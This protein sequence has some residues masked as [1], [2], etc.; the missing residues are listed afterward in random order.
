MLTFHGLGLDGIGT[1][2]TA[3]PA[4]PG[5]DR[6]TPTDRDVPD[7]EVG[8]IV[9]RGPHVF[10]GYFNRPELTA[11]HA[12]RRLAPHR[13]TSAGARTD[14][15][16][17][18]VGPK[19]RMI[20]S[21]GEN[22][23][24]AEVERALT[25]H[26]HVDAAAVIGLPDATWG[27]NVAAVVVRSEGATVTEQELIEHVRAADR[28]LQEAQVGD[29]RGGDPA[30]R[31]HPRLRPARRRLR[32]RRLPR[33]LTPVDEEECPHVPVRQLRLRRP[34]R[35]ARPGARRRRR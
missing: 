15:T 4:R 32:R 10:S 28:V 23:Y 1:Q 29:L 16:L 8:E 18:F 3:Q 34:D 35:P 31:L 12:A 6:R 27:Q 2:R 17:S 13:A 24:P 30:P 5:A 22:I 20:K 21:G 9:A 19:L 33:V 7:G 26:P 25:T 11:R 14:G